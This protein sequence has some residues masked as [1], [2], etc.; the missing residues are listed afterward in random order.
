MIV[1]KKIRDLSKVM[2]THIVDEKS[3]KADVAKIYLG[4]KGK[5]F[6]FSAFLGHQYL[7]YFSLQSTKPPPPKKKGE[8]D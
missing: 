5:P 2:W 4:T 3:F 7:H 8:R 1:S 6:F